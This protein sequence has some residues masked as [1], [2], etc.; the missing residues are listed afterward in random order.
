MPD[1]HSVKFFPFVMFGGALW[2]SG[3]ALAVPV[4]NSIGLAMGLL[5]WGCTNMLTGWATG[6]F[7]MFV[8]PESLTAP[9]LN[10]FGVLLVLVSLV[11]Y[12]QIKADVTPAFSTAARGSMLPSEAGAPDDEL[13]TVAEGLTGRKPLSRPAGIVLAMISGILYGTNFIPSTVMKE[14]GWGPKEPLDYIFS[15]YCGIFLTST[16]IFVFYAGFKRSNPRIFS[17]VLLPAIGSGVMWAIAQTCWFVANDELGFAVAFPMITSG[18]GI[19]SS[20]LG[21]LLFKEIR[22][23]RNFVF[24]GTS[25]LVSAI[26]CIMIGTSK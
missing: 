20:A 1:H 18:P 6:R 5:I 22:G 11:L 24:L 16:I 2:A 15:H 8:E 21:V 4:I 9:A 26:G 12:T 7:G 13:A 23:Q 25:I 14:H 17:R 19:V 10:T 3:N